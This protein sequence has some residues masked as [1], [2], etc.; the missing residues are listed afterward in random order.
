MYTAHLVINVTGHIFIVT[1]RIS[2][3]WLTVTLGY[4]VL[5]NV[6]CGRLDTIKPRD[7][8]TIKL[9]NEPVI[10]IIRWRKGIAFD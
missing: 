1:G 6:K 3:T 7:G 5:L 8:Y 10:G 4:Y 2:L 9:I